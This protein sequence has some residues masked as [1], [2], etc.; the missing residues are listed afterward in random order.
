MTDQKD[1]ADQADQTDSANA[2]SSDFKGPASD[3]TAKIDELLRSNASIEELVG[4]CLGSTITDSTTTML[5][6]SAKPSTNSQSS[7]F[8]SSQMPPPTWYPKTPASGPAPDPD[9]EDEDATSKGKQLAAEAQEEVAEEAEEEDEDEEEMYPTIPCPCAC[10]ENNERREGRPWL[11]FGNAAYVVCPLCWVDAYMRALGDERRG[12]D[13]HAY[14][15]AR[16]KDPL[17]P[18]AKQC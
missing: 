8:Y 13:C 1:Q 5:P 14:L 12:W 11:G 2:S 7:P 15:L 10:H 18:A 3:L 16:G 6:P 4:T 17:V 9:L